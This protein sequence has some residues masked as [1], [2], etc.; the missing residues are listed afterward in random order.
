MK[1]P[2]FEYHRPT[3]IE[4]ACRLL[5]TLENSKVLAGGQSLMAMLNLRY[6]YP[7]HLVDI[8][9]VPG[10]DGVIVGEDSLSIGAQVRQRRM[11]IDP[12]VAR[13]AP[14][15]AEALAMVGHRQTRNRGTLGGSLCHLDPAAELPLVALLYDATVRTAKAGGAGRAIPIGTFI[16]GFMQPAIDP[17]E[18][19]VGIDFPVWPAGHG[20]AFIER[21]RRHGDFAIASTACL[22]TTDSAGHIER[23]AVGVGGVGSVPIR[24]GVAEQALVGAHGD[25]E[26]FARAASHCEGIEAI[27]DFHGH[28]GYRRS[29]ATA[30][31]RRA[32]ATAY[33]RARHMEVAQ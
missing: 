18:L 14:I 26:I 1:P 12:D 19:V 31:V 27:A 24:L 21:A 33:K 32:L 2:P 28:A 3:S 15:F 16:A 7:D 20:Y 30:L 10:L 8:N 25:N 6:L 5:A 23:I 22:M 9:K 17:D 11:E 29:V 13:V 4:E